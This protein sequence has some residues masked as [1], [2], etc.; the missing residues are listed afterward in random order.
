M[1]IVAAPC[2]S[3]RKA[4]KKNDDDD[5][6]APSPEQYLSEKA[7][8]RNNYACPSHLADLDICISWLCKKNSNAYVDLN[9]HR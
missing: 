3:T 5:A 7:A 4:I 1:S 9:L 8:I 2:V 6:N